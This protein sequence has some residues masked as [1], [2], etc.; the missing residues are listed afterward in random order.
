[1]VVTSARTTSRPAFAERA[2]LSYSARVR[3]GLRRAASLGLIAAFAGCGGDRFEWDLVYE[4]ECL[5]PLAATFEASILRGTCGSTDVVWRE[6]TARGDRAALPP[7]LPAGRYGFAG[8]AADASGRWFAEGCTEEEV[9]HDG[10]LRVILT[11]DEPCPADAGNGVD[12]GVDSGPRDAGACLNNADC[13]P[14]D[15]SVWSDCIAPGGGDVCA[16]SGTQSRTMRTW[17]CVSDRCRESPNTVSQSCTVPTDGIE[18]GPRTAEP[19]GPCMGSAGCSTEG[20]QMR[21]VIVQECS[22]GSCG[23]SSRSE[24]QACT[25][26]TTD[27]AVCE[28][29]DF[30]LGNCTSDETC[31]RRGCDDDGD[32][33]G[34]CPDGGVPDCLGFGDGCCLC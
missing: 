20:T 12:G 16:S 18:C 26:A 17:T 29:V 11:S 21:M 31:E 10:A 8:R 5:A 7:E 32:C 22:T 27:G 28:D 33:D 9:P 25:I 34:L 14:P 13:P 19:W 6:T 1:M 15:D 30:C 4:R 24:S 2:H 23:T 3:L